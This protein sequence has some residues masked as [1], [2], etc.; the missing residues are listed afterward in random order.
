MYLPP[1]NSKKPRLRAHIYINRQSVALPTKPWLFCHA[2][3]VY[4]LIALTKRFSWAENNI[5]IYSVEI[6]V[7]SAVFCHSYTADL[8]GQ[9]V[10]IFQITLSSLET[11][12]SC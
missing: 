4:C 12:I 8:C 1:I 3:D 10:D 9:A 7:S 5:S 11:K 2:K 6:L